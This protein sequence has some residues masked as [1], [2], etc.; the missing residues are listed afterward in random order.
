MKPFVKNILLLVFIFMAGSV[1]AQDKPLFTGQVRDSV[2]QSPIAFASV[3]NLLTNKT[4]MSNKN[5]FFKIPLK[6]SD[7]LSFASVG[8]YFD[9]IRITLKIINDEAAVFFINPITH[10]LNDV[11]VTAKTKFSRYQ[12]DSMERRKNF[13]GTV[14]DHVQPVF[15]LANSGAGLGINLDHFYN[16]EKR[17]R[18][19]ISMLDQME[20]EEYINYRFTPVMTGGYT[21][22]SSDSLM[23]FMQ[24]YRP[25]YDWLR[26][27]RSDEDLVY[28]INDK[29]KLFF[30]RR[31]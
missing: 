25:S 13:F 11:T 23:L 26:K 29:L 4:V 17:K 24:T 8:Y 9:T 22:F 12:L 21:T 7:L 6:E 19:S 2:T 15:S 10:Q 3:T 31:D 20:Q 1:I 30:K 28:Y 18:R 14:S 16:R 5:G 27:H